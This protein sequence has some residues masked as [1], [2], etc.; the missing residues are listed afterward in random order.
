MATTIAAGGGDTGWPGSL[1]HF[2]LDVGLSQLTI[3]ALQSDDQGF[4]R[5]ATQEGLNRCAGHLFRACRHA[6]NASDRQ[7]PPTGSI[8]SLARSARDTALAER[9]RAAVAAHRSALEQREPTLACS[10]G[11]APRPWAAAWPA[12]GDWEQ[13][14]GLADRCLYAAQGAGRNAWVPARQRTGCACTAC[15]PAARPNT[16]ATACASCLPP[17]TR[18]TSRVE[19]RVRRGAFSAADG[20][21]CCCARHP[22]TGGA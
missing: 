9:L 2:G 17:R 5:I 18:R 11:F 22:G 16:S 4:P 8:D 12:L 13:S 3:T 7:S 19:R 10:I 1:A 21:A 6:L 15:S 20:G 14:V